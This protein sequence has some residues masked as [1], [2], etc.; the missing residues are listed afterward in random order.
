M[1]RLSGPYHGFGRDVKIARGIRT[2]IVSDN[3]ECEGTMACIES[4]KRDCQ[5]K[6]LNKS[7]GKERKA[8][9]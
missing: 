4:V 2:L 5:W 7:A 1:H 9:A 3:R 8:R 6:V